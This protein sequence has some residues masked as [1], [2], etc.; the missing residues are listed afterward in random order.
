M[1]FHK[2]IAACEIVAVEIFALEI[3]VPK[4]VV[5]R[6]AVLK[7]AVLKIAVLEIAVLE[8]TSKSSLARSLSTITRPITS[9]EHK[10]SVKTAGFAIV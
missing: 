7:I 3:I 1:I 2:I 4:I 10:S 5:P 9:V 6:I 8:I